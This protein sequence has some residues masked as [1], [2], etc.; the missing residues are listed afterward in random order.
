MEPTQLLP[1]DN[2]H[3]INVWLQI[4]ISASDPLSFAFLALVDFFTFICISVAVVDFAMWKLIATAVLMRAWT[5]SSFVVT[6][7]FSKA[8]RSSRV[9]GDQ[10]FKSALSCS[11]SPSISD[12]GMGVPS[13]KVMDMVA[14]ANELEGQ[15]RPPASPP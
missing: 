6:R 12:R 9:P 1:I 11:S 2:L 3:I 5:C 7:S 8:A 14:R 4:S 10:P 15:V 13:F